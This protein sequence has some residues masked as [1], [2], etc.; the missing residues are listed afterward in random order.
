VVRIFIVLSDDGTAIID[1]AN[2]TRIIPNA[3]TSAGKKV[4]ISQLSTAIFKHSTAENIEFQ[5][6]GSTEE[7]CHWMEVVCEPYSRAMWEE[8]I[9]VVEE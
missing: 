1:F 5:F 3:S 4:L 6:D 9:E 7:F 2:F 8:T